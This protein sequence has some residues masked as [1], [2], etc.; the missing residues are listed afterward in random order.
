M[1]TQINFARFRH[2]PTTVGV[3]AIACL[4]SSTAQAQRPS[5]AA[6]Q[7]QLTAQQAQIAT[8]Q[9]QVMPNMAGYVTMDVSTPSRPTLRV[10]GANVQVVNGTGGTTNVNGLGN[11]ILGYNETN[12]NALT[13]CSDGTYTNAVGCFG[14]GTWGANQHTGSHN[15]V[16]GTGHSYTSYGGLIAGEL[17]VINRAFASVS[18]GDSNAAS[19]QNSNAS[20]GEVN[21]ASGNYSSVSGGANNTASGALSVVSGGQLNNASGSLS[22]VSGGFNRSASGTFDW[23]AGTLH[24]P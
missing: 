4:L 20:G 24:S 7:S 10:A 6:L 9:S 18:G 23:V 8:L 14:H 21:T 16:I 17:N 15:L 13:I 3:L 2:W 19:G 5:I 1:N 12:A 22:N 11:V